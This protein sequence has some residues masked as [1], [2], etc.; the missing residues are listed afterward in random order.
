MSS[1]LKK[2]IYGSDKTPLK[3]GEL[4][5][6]CYVLE[7]GTRVLSRSG[8]QK[9]IGYTGKSGTM[10]T[11]FV[12]TKNGFSSEIVAGVKNPIPF[13]R[14]DAGGS[15]PVSNGHEATLFIDICGAIIDLDRAGA[16]NE[17]QKIYAF[18]ADIIIR[19][20]AKVGIIALIDEVTGY[21][22]VRVSNALNDMLNKFLLEEAKKYQVTFPLELYKQ[23]FRLNSWDWKPENAQRRSPLVGKWTINLIYQRIAPGLLKELEIRNPKNP[24]GYREHKHFQFLTEEIGTPKLREFFGGLIALAKANSSWRKYMDMVNRVYPKYGDTLFLDFPDND[25]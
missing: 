9:A 19:S 21:Q 24:K 15:Q 22:N 11:S 20:V 13:E 18:F 17:S 25:I 7:D 1:K 8:I 23:W 3:F 4:E 5:I 14:N 6:P 16:L 10:L 2:A 12:T